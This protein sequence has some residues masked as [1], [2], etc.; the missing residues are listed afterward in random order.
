[1]KTNSPISDM[2]T[3]ENSIIPPKYSLNPNI[4]LSI[5][6]DKI[7]AIIGSNENINAAFT[8]V[9]YFCTLVCMNVTKNEA[10]IAL[11]AR[12]IIKFTLGFKNTV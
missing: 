7:L 10:I 4:S 1:M 9:V 8:G 11:N 5:N 2:I 12:E 3:P 6:I